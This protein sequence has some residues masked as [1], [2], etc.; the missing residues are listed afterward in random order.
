MCARKID[1]D[2][3]LAHVRV[4]PGKDLFMLIEKDHV[5]I[6]YKV[7]VMV[8]QPNASIHDCL[9]IG[10]LSMVVFFKLCYLLGP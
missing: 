5:F 7:A 4:N 6:Y 8:S 10:F 2:M 3:I 1:F 9:C